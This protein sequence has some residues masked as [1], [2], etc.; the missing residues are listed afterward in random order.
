[1]AFRRL[2]DGWIQSDEG[3][4][5]RYEDRL[6]VLYR[7]GDRITR[8]AGEWLATDGF[9]LET[10]LLGAWQPP[11]EHEPVLRERLVARVKAALEFT[12]IEVTVDTT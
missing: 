1:M 8:V 9:V 12:G 6:H 2:L 3:F 11:H 7:E 5:V 4:S 10:Q